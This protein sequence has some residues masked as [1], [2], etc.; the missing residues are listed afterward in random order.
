MD[1]DGD[2]FRMV[3]AYESLSMDDNHQ[4]YTKSKSS[5]AINYVDILKGQLLIY[6]IYN[7]KYILCT[8]SFHDT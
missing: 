3:K 1:P 4:F 8:H 2:R 7:Y 5:K 6:H